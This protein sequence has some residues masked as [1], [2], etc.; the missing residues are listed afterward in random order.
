MKNVT[1]LIVSL[2]LQGASLDVGELALNG[3]RIFFKFYPS[4]LDTGLQLSPFKLPLTDKVLE[5]DVPIFD[6]LF[7]V[8]NDSLPDGWGRLLMDRTLLSSGI[9]LNKITPLDRLSFVGNKGKGALCYRPATD[10]AYSD[11]DM[12]HLDVIAAEAQKVLSGAD[13]S[14]IDHLLRLGGSS[15][16]ARPKILVGYHPASNRLLPFSENLPVGYEHWII[17]FPASTDPHD[18]AQI[19]YAYHKMAL[20]T[21][22]DMSECRLFEGQN[23]QKYFGA[24]RFDRIGNQRLHLH[25]AAGL[26]HDNFRLSSMDYGHLMDAAFRLERHVQAYAKILRLAAFNIYAHNRDDHSNN[27]SFLMEGNGKWAF[28]PAYDLSFSFS[29]HGHHSTSVAGESKSPGRAQL[30]E[31]ASV[32]GVSAVD[33]IIEQ[34]RTIVANWGHYADTCGV[35]SSTKASIRLVLEQIKD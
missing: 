14:A 10:D 23:G 8:F 28:A 33:A 18:I 11:S 24:K 5:P 13:T 9:K 1:R 32:F 4:F 25:S 12:I 31:L 26:L 19:E 35:S 20:D 3:K 17:K 30:Q 16:G 21:G 2:S 34:V 15:G 22:I 7:G 6:G 27:F 29:S